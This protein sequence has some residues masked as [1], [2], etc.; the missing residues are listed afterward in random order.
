MFDCALDLNN[1][2]L[3]AD[4]LYLCGVTASEDLKKRREQIISVGP[5]NRHRLPIIICIA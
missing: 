1:V 2:Y 5:Q 4:A 3:I